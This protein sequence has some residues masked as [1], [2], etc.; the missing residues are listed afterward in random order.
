ASARA[1][2]VQ[3]LPPARPDAPPLRPILDAAHLLLPTGLDTACRHAAVAHVAA[4]LLHSTP[5]QPAGQLK[6][7]GLAVISAVEDARVEQ[8][9][10]RELPGVRRW[11]LAALRASVQPDGL[12]CMALLSRLSLALHDDDYRDGNHWVDKART[13]FAETRRTHGL[14]DP[15]AFRRLASVLGNDLGQ[16]R[17][18]F[19][20]RQ[21]AVPAPY[22]DDNSYLWNHGT[23]AEADGEPLTVQLPTPPGNRPRDDAQAAAP[24]AVH[25]HSHPE[26][27]YR[28][29]I[30][31]RDWCTVHEHPPTLSGAHTSHALALAAPLSW[32]RL[33]RSLRLRHQREGESLDLDA[34]VD[35][36]IR[37]RL[38]QPCDDRLYQRALAAPRQ[39]SVL[40]LLDLSLSTA[41]R[42]GPG[43]PSMLELEQ[44]AALLLGRTAR[45]GGDRLAIDGFCSDTRERVHYQRLI[46]F[47]AALDAQALQ[48]VRSVHAQYSTRLGAGL[49]H[50]AQRLRAERSGLRALIVLT[51]GEPSDVDVHDARYL[52]EDARAAAEATARAG[53]QV[54]GVTVDPGAGDYARR[55]F[56]ARHHQVLPTPSQLPRLLSRLY[57]RLAQV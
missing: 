24:A 16:M 33:D 39:L 27:D 35:A 40:V 52:V 34:A 7:L 21:F 32:R 29:A 28:S 50:A 54:W 48:R 8:L 38:Q 1:L 12:S 44:T 30:E 57:T 51:D 25:L 10:M 41:A 42:A 2:A 3:P 37:H 11:F 45:A 5:A 26:W 22:R 46:D 23:A 15:D 19:D 9:L 49:R 17:V 31:R 56:G 18:Q 13:L 6:P 55:I 4:H 20:S 36:R 14:H 43:A 47:G 53:L